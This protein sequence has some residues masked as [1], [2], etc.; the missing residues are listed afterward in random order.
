MISVVCVYNN[1][2]ILNK[3]LLSCLDRQTAEHE[4][5][6]IDNREGRFTS[7]AEA[8]NH[9]GNRARGQYIMFLHQDM[10]LGSESWLQD[11]EKLM[12]SLPHLGV[13]G[14]AGMTK[15]GRHWVERAK[16]SIRSID[17]GPLEGIGLRRAETPVEVQTLDECLLIVPR[18]VFATLQF[19][20]RAFDGWDCYGADYSLSAQQAGL[21]AYVIPGESDHCCVR[22]HHRIWE[23]RDLLKYQRRLCAKHQRHA[24]LIRT[25][26]GSISPFP[27]A[28]RSGSS[29]REE[30][31]SRTFRSCRSR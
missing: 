3:I 9:G 18:E 11:A 13:A 20:P 8:L 29:E 30:P 7:A 6:L 1:E 26:M 2:R 12:G 25:W 14:V 21:R 22:A 5:I 17:G 19:D 23:F 27:L 24:R 28:G 31:H 4:R 10:W 15:T 16:F